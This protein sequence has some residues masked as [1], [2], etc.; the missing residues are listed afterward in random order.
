MTTR[1][2]APSDPEAAQLGLFDSADGGIPQP[3]RRP[4]PLLHVI[5]AALSVH[6]G[7]SYDGLWMNL[8]R[9]NNDGTGW[10]ADRPASSCDEPASAAA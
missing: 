5:A 7:V 10:H 9:D 4:Q 3:G 2:L 8:Y 6:Y 1:A